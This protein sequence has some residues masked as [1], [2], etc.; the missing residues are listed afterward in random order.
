MI[1]LTFLKNLVLIRQANQ[2][3]AMDRVHYFLKKEFEF[4]PNI[5]YGCHDLLMICINLSYIVI[6]NFKGAGSCWLLLC[7]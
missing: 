1:E 3:S 2:N 4:Q 6:L 7:Y 5:S